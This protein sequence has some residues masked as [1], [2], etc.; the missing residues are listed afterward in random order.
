ML[1][2]IM[3]DI[4]KQQSRRE[5]FR[6]Y[7]LKNKNKKRDPNNNEGNKKRGRP[8]KIIPPFSITKL[9]KPITLSFN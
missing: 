3:T 7:Y 8:R 1:N 9:D 6:Q 4:I 2:Y 5:Y